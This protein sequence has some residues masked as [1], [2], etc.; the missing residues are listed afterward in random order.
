[1]KTGVQDPTGLASLGRM[2]QATF[3][4][5]HQPKTTTSGTRTQQRLCIPVSDEGPKD[6]DPS[7][8]ADDLTAIEEAHDNCLTQVSSQFGFTVKATVA[9][10]TSN[11]TSWISLNARTVLFQLKLETAQATPSAPLT[12]VAKHTNSHPEPAV[13]TQWLFSSKQW[14]TFRPTTPVKSTC[15]SWTPMAR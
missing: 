10:E 14:S 13:Q 5:T 2:H 3:Q 8:Q 11:P 1:M 12:L 6:G 9:L 4:A 7:Q 15:P